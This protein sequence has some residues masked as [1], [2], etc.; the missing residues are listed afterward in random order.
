MAFTTEIQTDDHSGTVTLNP[1]WLRIPAAVKYSGIE[2][3][4]LCELIRQGKIKSCC[5]KAHK[6]AQRGIRLI[7]REAID[8]FM[9]ALQP[10][11][12]SGSQS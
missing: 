12:Q 1:R 8:Q 5:I 4:R 6:F 3:A 2:R 11:E 9:L 10:E 7:D